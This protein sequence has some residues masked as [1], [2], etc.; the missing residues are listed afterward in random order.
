MTELVIQPGEG[1]K[2]G[3]GT[4]QPENYRGGCTRW[5]IIEAIRD[6]DCE[7]YFQGNWKRGNFST[8]V[9]LFLP[10]T[11][12]ASLSGISYLF[13]GQP[14]PTPSSKPNQTFF[15]S[16]SQE[17]SS[18]PHRVLPTPS[19]LQQ[20]RPLCPETLLQ[21]FQ[22]FLALPWD[23]HDGS[24][25]HSKCTINQ[26]RI[27]HES[28]LPCRFIT[29]EVT[30]CLGQEGT[31]QQGDSTGAFLSTLVAPRHPAQPAVIFPKMHI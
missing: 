14:S 26:L 9:P 21:K 20:P 7:G 2:E 23:P 3:Q 10:P 17:A 8:P 28:P 25:H 18:S 15:S 19:S 16:L 31:S 13:P 22:A 30:P 5:R 6:Q 24:H 12:L 27:S 29:C 1:E 11:F 4:Q